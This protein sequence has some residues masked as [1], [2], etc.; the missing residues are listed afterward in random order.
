MKSIIIWKSIYKENDRKKTHDIK[1]I[2]RTKE[3][4]KSSLHKRQVLLFENISIRIMIY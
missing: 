1:Y 3:N 2:I 4:D